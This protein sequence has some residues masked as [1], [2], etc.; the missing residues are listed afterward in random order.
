[1]KFAEIGF[2]RL[3]HAGSLE[4]SEAEMSSLIETCRTVADR[5]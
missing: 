4:F 2:E 1:M 5:H 3:F